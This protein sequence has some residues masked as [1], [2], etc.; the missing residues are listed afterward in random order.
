MCSSRLLNGESGYEKCDSME[1]YSNT[2]QTNKY[3]NRM[4]VEQRESEDEIWVPDFYSG[5]ERVFSYLNPFV[6]FLPFR[7]GLPMLPT[8]A[9]LMYG[10]LVS[11]WVAAPQTEGT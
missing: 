11:A 7:D 4:I 1:I 8:F 10:E 9:N 6:P 5:P 3:S 2:W